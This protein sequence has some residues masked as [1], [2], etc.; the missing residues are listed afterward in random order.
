MS[1]VAT[2]GSTSFRSLSFNG[3]VACG[4]TAAGTALC[5]GS[6]LY[7]QIGDGPG[8]ARCYAGL[9]PCAP[10]PT[11]VAG[12][13]AFDTVVTGITH[14]CGIAADGPSYCWGDN[15]RSQL[16]AVT[17]ETCDDGLDATPCA[18]SPLE[19]Q[20]DLRFV[21]LAL[22][23]QH[24]CGLTAVGTV[25]CW[26]DGSVGQRGDG[27]TGSGPSPVAVRTA[28]GEVW[29]WGLADLGQ[30]G[31]PLQDVGVCV[32]AGTGWPC[33]RIPVRANSIPLNTL[34][35]G[36][37]FNCGMAADDGRPLCWGSNGAGQ[38]GTGDWQRSWSA[39]ASPIAG[40]RSR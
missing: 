23:A 32:S 35:S 18:T 15:V 28:G 17:D 38:L 13:L 37:D 5:W 22:G 1:P 7:G 27:A 33:A 26:G 39:S 36:G 14:V 11:P 29:C 16:G 2:A 25:W 20:T 21:A 8:S 24:T 6:D 9:E 12:G 34:N 31:V 19:V 30:L 3:F 4:L 40:A 10:Q